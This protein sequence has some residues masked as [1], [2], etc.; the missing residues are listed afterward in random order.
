MVREMTLSEMYVEKN[1]SSNTHKTTTTKRRLDGKK[2][3]IRFEWSYKL[4]LCV[5]W[6]RTSVRRSKCEA[7]NRIKQ[8]HFSAPAVSF[9]S[10]LYHCCQSISPLDKR[11]PPWLQT[12]LFP[13]PFWT[14][15]MWVCPP[16][17]TLHQKLRGRLSLNTR[18]SNRCKYFCT[19]HPL[20]SDNG[21][22][23]LA[24]KMKASFAVKEVC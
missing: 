22:W 7:L 16:P 19:F 13:I 20:V 6:S 5:R 21:N 24:Q 10:S 9:V 15:L 14:N 8:L 11:F 1:H 12:R 2:K 23:E 4:H 3:L 17:S 18:D